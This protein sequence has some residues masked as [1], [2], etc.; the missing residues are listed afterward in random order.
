M[1]LVDG[2]GRSRP[3]ATARILRDHGD[4]PAPTTPSGASTPPPVGPPKRP[5]PVDDAARGGTDAT[6]GSAP[7]GGTEAWR[8]EGDRQRPDPGDPRDV[9]REWRR[10]DQ[11]IGEA[12]AFYRSLG[13]DG[14][15]DDGGRVRGVLSETHPAAEAQP[16]MGGTSTIRVGGRNEDGRYMSD[17]G[18][19]AHEYAHLVMRAEERQH[20]STPADAHPEH[21]AVHEGMADAMA[22]MQ[23][24][25]YGGYRDPSDPGNPA[26][27]RMRADVR[28]NPQVHYAGG[29]VSDAAVEIQQELG[30][31]RTAEVL[32]GAMQDE[33]FGYDTGFADLASI[34]ADVARERFGDDAATAVEGAF[35]DNGYG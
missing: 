25:S 35:A 20:G 32:H 34:A 29:I 15:N 4:A 11:S 17:A 23:L 22:F 12:D 18:T 10:L 3:A 14:W 16:G 5:A 33:R 7:T 9:R 2:A 6:T 31:D 8:R 21:G 30:F 19:V 13:R 26:I 28:A 1:T 24:E 27:A